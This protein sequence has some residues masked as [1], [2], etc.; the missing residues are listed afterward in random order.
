MQPTLGPAEVTVFN[1]LEQ[2]GTI[3]TP[4]R[5]TTN[6][7]TV[8][9]RLWNPDAHRFLPFDTI[10][11]AVFTERAG[12][13]EITGT[14]KTLRSEIGLSRDDAQTRLHVKVTSCATCN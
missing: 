10:T 4:C 8:A 5:L 3:I 7:S 1:H 11:D 13:T 9:V 2:D 14:S 12:Y 6:G